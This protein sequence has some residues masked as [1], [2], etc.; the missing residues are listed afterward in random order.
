MLY[1]ENSFF[2]KV[3]VENFVNYHNGNHITWSHASPDI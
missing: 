3:M 1:E 2:Q